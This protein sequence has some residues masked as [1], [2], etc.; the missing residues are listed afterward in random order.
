MIA[1]FGIIAELRQIK[2]TRGIQEY[3]KKEWE[4]RKDKPSI[5]EELDEYLLTEGEGEDAGTR[6]EAIGVMIGRGVSRS[7]RFAAM[8]G[9]SVDSKRQAFYDG[10]VS[11]GIKDSMPQ[12]YKILMKVAER[13]GLDIEDIIGKEEMPL[14]LNSLQKRGIGS[15]MM[16][17]NPGSRQGVPEMR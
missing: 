14:F 17:N 4:A 11:E 13:F 12:K 8:Q 9:K 16:G 5:A 3:I 15:E 7:M 2:L 1:V 6:M 10:K